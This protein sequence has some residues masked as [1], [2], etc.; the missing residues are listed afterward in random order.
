MVFTQ[1]WKP[2]NIGSDVG[3]DVGSDASDDVENWY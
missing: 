3:N 1:R 2:P